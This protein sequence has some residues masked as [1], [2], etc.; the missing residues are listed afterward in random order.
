VQHPT[1]LA[2]HSVLLSAAGDTAS[3]RGRIWREEQRQLLCHDGKLSMC[4]LLLPI[5][6]LLLLVLTVSCCC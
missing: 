3:S 5:L 2:G 1:L 6:L 4:Q